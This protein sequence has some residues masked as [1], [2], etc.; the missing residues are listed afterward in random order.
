MFWINNFIDAIK[1]NWPDIFE[2]VILLFKIVE[3]LHEI[4]LRIVDFLHE[5]NLRI[6]E[7]LHKKNLKIA[8][9]LHEKT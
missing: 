4:H 5:I 8:E 7:F 6:V 3:F 1:E 9:F 2:D